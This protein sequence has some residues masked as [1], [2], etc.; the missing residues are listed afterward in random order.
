MN[1]FLAGLIGFVVACL[2]ISLLDDDGDLN[3][4]TKQ[5]NPLGFDL[6]LECRCVSCGQEHTV[7]TFS[8]AYEAWD[9]WG[10]HLQHAMWF[11]SADE[12]E[13]L[14]SSL[15]PQCFDWACGEEDGGE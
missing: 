2:I 8:G 10:I 6:G 14:L 4:T 15:C 13:W 3:M 1:C 5:Q 7:W 9:K 12:R 11:L